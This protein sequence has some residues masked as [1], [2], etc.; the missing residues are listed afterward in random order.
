MKPQEIIAS[1]YLGD[2]A[3][4]AVLV[5][6]WKKTIGIQV[7]VISRL[8]PGAKTWDYYTDEDITDGWLVFEG[9]KRCFFDPS[10]S[11]PNDLINEIVVDSIPNS[12]GAYTFKISIGSVSSDGNYVETLIAIEAE[13]VRVAKM[14]D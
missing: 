2:R 9:V 11:L 4:K 8:R 6:T 5:N 14:L 1:L 3:C 12:P 7:D 10:G 13:S